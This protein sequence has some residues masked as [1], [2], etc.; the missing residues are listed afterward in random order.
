VKLRA[1]FVLCKFFYVKTIIACRVC[2][3]IGLNFAPKDLGLT[4]NLVE[5]FLV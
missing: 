3:P 2:L 5:D 4:V 1:L